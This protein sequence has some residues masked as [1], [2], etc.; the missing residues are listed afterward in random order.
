MSHHSDPSASG[1]SKFGLATIID[2]GITIFLRS[3]EI[4]CR[5]S[6]LSDYHPEIISNSWIK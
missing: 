6:P 3:F 2:E 1:L 4:P 5:K